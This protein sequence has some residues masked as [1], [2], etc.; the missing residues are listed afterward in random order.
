ML[1]EA[2]WTVIFVAHGELVEPGGHRPVLFELVDA[3]LH[4]MTLLVK[5]RVAPGW[6]AAVGSLLTPVGGLVVLFRDGGLDSADSRGWPWRYTPCR[7]ALDPAGSWDDPALIGRP[8]S[9]PAPS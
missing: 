6:P 1:I 8:G 7:P 2:M 4:G 9:A 3:A 5:L